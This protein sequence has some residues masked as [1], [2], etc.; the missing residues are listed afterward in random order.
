MLDSGVWHGKRI[1][2]KEFVARA[3][4]PLVKINGTR[5]YGLLWWP[6]E[7]PWRG[8]TVKTFAMLGAG[9]NVMFVF[10]ELELVVATTGGSYISRG[11]RFAGGELLTNLVLPAVR[12]DREEGRNFMAMKGMVEVSLTPPYATP[13]AVRRAQ[14]P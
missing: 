5:P 8:R 4:S 9:G 3:A 2:S 12:Q 14:A 6:E 13:T 1:L 10:P 11:W 7:K